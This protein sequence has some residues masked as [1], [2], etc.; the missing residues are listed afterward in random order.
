[1]G[2][3][4]TDESKK[5][6]KHCIQETEECYLRTIG[7]EAYSL[8]LGEPI[9]VFFS[10]VLKSFT[11][12][13]ALPYTLGKR[14]R[15]RASPLASSMIWLNK[16]G[17]IEPSIQNILKK[18]LIELRDK[19]QTGEQRKGQE[20]KRPE[21]KTGWSLAEGVSTWSTDL[22]V[23]ALLQ[24][25]SVEEINKDELKDAL[26][27]LIDQKDVHSGGWAYQNNCTCKVNSI[28][29]AMTVFALAL[30]KKNELN[31]TASETESRA[32][33]DAIT[34][35]SKYLVNEFNKKKGYWVF[36]DKPSI[37]ATVWSLIALK[38]VY[39][40]DN[41][42]VDVKEQY[43]EIR[44][45]GI[46]F[47]MAILP[48]KGAWKEEQI[49]KEAGA[50]YASQKNYYSFTAT[51]I[52][53]LLDLGISPY[54]PKIITQIRWLLD[55]KGEWK[56]L[57]YDGKEVCS[58]IYAMV[59]SSIYYWIKKMEEKS[60][61]SVIT[62]V[63]GIKAKIFKVLCGYENNNNNPYI[64]LKSNRVLI[65]I[66]VFVVL[67]ISLFW[68]QAILAII[69]KIVVALLQ[70]IRPRTSDII[71]NLISTVLY[72]L[73]SGIFVKGTKCVVQKF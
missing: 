10:P 44:T 34:S 13:G 6:N 56:I 60:V 67:L 40:I 66:G 32:L 43:N 41:N 71:V 26:K 22:A 50:N 57:E 4:K 46:K 33:T 18:K 3:Y 30:A 62:Q 58:F 19:H 17:V 7:N 72:V 53:F 45:K 24:D 59:A 70:I 48:K 21:D 63:G 16:A 54:E 52:P 15:Y 55:H 1:M 25:S 2:G 68:G 5:E 8:V 14:E 37:Y 61:V 69:K 23:I 49:V 39:A 11:D 28:T 20:R 42:N 31:L 29:T 51:L 27:W 47:I 35:G 64:L 73:I 36:D 65:G 9:E 12:D 38:E